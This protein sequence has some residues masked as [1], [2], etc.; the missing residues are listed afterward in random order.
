[1]TDISDYSTISGLRREN[2]VSIVDGH[3]T[4]LYFLHNSAGNEV[5]ITNYGGAIAAV[6]VP[7]REGRR[8]NVIQGYDSIQGHVPTPQCHLF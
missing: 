2:F 7:D 6:M 3:D 5:A 8:A 1:M 4:N